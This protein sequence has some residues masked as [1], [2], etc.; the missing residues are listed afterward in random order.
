MRLPTARA[1][2]QDSIP[3]TK[4]A[5]N[6]QQAYYNKCFRVC[7]LESK[8]DAFQTFF[9]RLMGLAFPGDFMP[10]GRQGDE[11]NNGFLTSERTLFQVYAPNEMSAASAVAKIQEDFAG[12]KVY[13]EQYLGKWVFVHNADNGLSPN[14]QKALLTHL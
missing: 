8:R 13:W 1:S 3:Q 5:M 11:K 14:A 4:A 9:E 7:F 6:L 2:E 12:A 10:W